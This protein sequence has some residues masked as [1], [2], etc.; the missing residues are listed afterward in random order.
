VFERRAGDLIDRPFTYITGV[1]SVLTGATLLWSIFGSLKMESTGVGIIVRGKHFVTIT[2]KQQG[3]V[4]KQFFALDQDVKRGDILMSLD[5]EAN[6]LQLDASIKTLDIA[7]PLTTL[8]ST[9][10]SQ[11]EVAA[12]S[13]V[14]GAQEIYQRNAS[15]LRNLIIKQ[16]KAYAGVQKLY[17]INQASSDEL[18]SSYSSLLDLKQQLLGL[19]NDI[20]QQQINLQQ[21][22]QSNAQAK[23]NLA[24]Q[25]ISTASSAA[26]SKISI[27]QSRFIRSPI[28]GTVIS[29]SV[30]LGGFAN[31]GDPLMTIV[32]KS[33][34]LRAIL[35]IGSDKYE[36]VKKGDRVFLSPSASPSIR[37]GFIKGTVI[38]KSDSP[39]TSAELLRAFGSDESV[40]TL[41]QSFG[42]GGQV[43][44]PYL[45]DVAVEEIG[46]QPVWTLGRQPPWGVRPGSAATARIISDQAR[47]ISLLLPFLRGL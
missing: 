20:R 43:N 9:A 21:L 17:A 4:A 30:P 2:S 26:T 44:F 6:Q 1:L 12:S 24:S 29:Y 35:L 31:P 33:G 46:T 37:F 36:R 8:S 39:A 18:A 11:A 3:V 45:V 22:V 14:A 27:N 23:I 19:E 13:N 32:P 10:G 42:S 25:N 15:I 7:A 34:P 28:D 47:P 16:E 41:M 5:T 40:Q 38:S